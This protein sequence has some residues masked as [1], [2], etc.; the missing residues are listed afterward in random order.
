[1]MLLDTHVVIWYLTNDPQLPPHLKQQISEESL[2]YVSSVVIWE[3]A[4]KGALGK[5][6]L[7]GKLMDSRS[8]EAI[9]EECVSQ[10]FELLDIR[11]SHAAQ[12]PFLSGNHKDPFDRLLAAQAVEQ[13]LALVSR[14]TVFDNFSPQ[15]QR[16]WSRPSAE[17]DRSHAKKRPQKTAGKK[18]S[19]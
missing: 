6:E 12:A 15:L 7:G 1:M 4:I 11:A 19:I 14:D 16:I 18:G 8:V 9:I 5:L 17:T 3:I 13:G 2:V 10:E